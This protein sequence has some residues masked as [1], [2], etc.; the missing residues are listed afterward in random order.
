MNSK[1][2]KWVL[3][4][5]IAVAINVGIWFLGIA[6]SRLAIAEV[7]KQTNLANQQ[8]SQLKGRL[9]ILE[10][11]D[12][13]SLEQ[14]QSEQLV[15]IPD[16]GMLRE[17]MTELEAEA[18]RTGN[19]LRN[20]SL[21]QPAVVGLFQRLEITLALGGD[22]FG[23]YSY[24]KYLETHNRLILVDSFSLGST[25][26]EISATIK[27]YLFAGDFDTYTPHQ[28]PGRNNPFVPR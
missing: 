18:A 6:P 23:L 26:E 10:A 3:I 4:I 17:M 19:E 21:V 1:Q 9:E 25:G 15:L 16:L 8:A 13:E 14:E 27:L 5:L 20:M 22:Y 24:I 28:A 2:Q 7:E 11:I 12:I